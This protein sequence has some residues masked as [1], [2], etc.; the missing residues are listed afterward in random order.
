MAY[1]IWP[2]IGIVVGMLVG[3]SSQRRIYRP[4]A[5]GSFL[6]SAFGGLV[7]G[8]VGDGLPHALAGD[9]T[10]TSIIGAVIGALVFCWAV[11]DR[12]SDLEP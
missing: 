3:A 12:A 9:V 6:A 5:N 2:L 11:R 8:V 10:L 7:G 4:S 1:V